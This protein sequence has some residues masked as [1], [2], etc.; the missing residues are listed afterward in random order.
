MTAPGSA[1][2]LMRHGR[3]MKRRCPVRQCHGYPPVDSWRV[4]WVPLRPSSHRLGAV[5]LRPPPGGHGLPGR[6]L[7]CPIRLAPAA[8]R[9]RETCPPHDCPTALGILRGASRVPPGRRTPHAGGGMVLSL[10]HPRL[11]APQ[12][13]DRGEGRLPSGTMALPCGRAWVLTRSARVGFPARRADRVDQ[14]GQGQ[15]STAGLAHAAGAAPWRSSAKPPPLAGWPP[16]HGALQAQAA[17]TIAWSLRLSSH[18]SVGACTPTVF[19]HSAMPLARRTERALF[20]V[21]CMR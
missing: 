20:A 5:A 3:T 7:L 12:A 21:T 2:V 9:C 10:P 18:G 13:W 1:P 11:A 19:P 17:H 6:R 15:R 14:G 4:P 16:A 8:A